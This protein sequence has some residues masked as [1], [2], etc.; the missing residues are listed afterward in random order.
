MR[1]TKRFC[2][3][4][5]ICLTI[6]AIVFGGGTAN[7][8]SETDTA[9]A[10]LVE[11]GIYTGDNNGNLNLDKSLTRAE[12]AVIVT[13]LIFMSNPS[14]WEMWGEAHWRS[15]EMSTS[16]FSDVPDWAIP[17]VEC[18]YS[19][20][21]IKGVS[22]TKFD[23]QGTVTPQMACTVLLRFCNITPVG[24]TPDWSYETAIAKAQS[25]GIAPSEGL[26]GSVITR[27][28][29]AIMAYR[30][31]QFTEARSEAYNAELDANWAATQQ[32]VAEEKAQME[33]QEAQKQLLLETI[34][35]DTFADEIRQEFYLLLNNHR[36]SNGMRELEINPALQNYADIRAAE[37]RTYYGHTR[38]DKTAAGSGWH[39]SQNMVNSRYA[40][41]IISLGMYDIDTDA[42]TIATIFFEGWKQSSGHNKHMLYNFNDN[43]T[44][45]LGLDLKIESGQ[46][47]SPGVW[48]S[49]Y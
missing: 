48:A 7:A 39:N 41:N 36:R 4:L 19:A 26:N 44:M 42:K 2:G 8:A 14:D 10:Y 15:P 22:D 45:A 25:I 46:L 40:E 38:P 35:L 27:S 37:V 32:M 49:G 18:C 29:V 34:N 6:G 5:V 33:Q 11:H 13:R 20:G 43:I 16:K 21:Y 12:L 24:Q 30:S 1:M 28:A 9:V 3:M 23:P 31:A 47:T 17:Q